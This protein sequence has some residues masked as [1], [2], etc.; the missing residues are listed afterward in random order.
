[1]GRLVATGRDEVI[2]A[3]L[4]QNIFVVKTKYFDGQVFITKVANR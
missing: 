4:N 3:D 1:M 2:I